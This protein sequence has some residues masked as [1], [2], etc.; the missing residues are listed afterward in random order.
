VNYSRKHNKGQDP[1]RFEIHPRGNNT[2]HLE[3]QLRH[4]THQ[5]TSS[6]QFARTN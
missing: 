1:P 6:I 5:P 3:S 2:G 4:S